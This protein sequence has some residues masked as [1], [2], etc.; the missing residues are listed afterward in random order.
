MFPALLFLKSAGRPRVK[1]NEY[2]V[3]QIYKAMEEEE[4]EYY[5]SARYVLES[6]P[7]LAGVSLRMVQKVMASIRKKKKDNQPP[8]QP[9]RRLLF[10]VTPLLATKKW[11]QKQMELKYNIPELQEVV[12]LVNEA[13]NGKT[14][15]RREIGQ[16]LQ[17]ELPHWLVAKIVKKNNAY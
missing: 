9:P 4:K 15:E 6:L 10:D 5:I 13:M 12:D 7:C 11:T 2:M 8:S 14:V 3:Y 17:N 1:V 16:W